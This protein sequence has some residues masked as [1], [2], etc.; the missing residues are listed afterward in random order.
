MAKVDLAAVISPV[1][2]N[3]IIVSAQDE[4]G[5]PVASLT[6]GSFSVRAMAISPL[7]GTPYKDDRIDVPVNGV[8]AV[9]ASMPNDWSGF[10]D[11]ALGSVGLAGALT[12]EDKP[13]ADLWPCVYL[14][15]V[16]APN[17]RFRGQTMIVPTAVS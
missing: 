13:A 9:T 2:Q 17:N 16:R 4:R 15:Q 14:V 6:H 8:S 10:Y 7:Q 1:D 12:V 3:H 11:L 5:D